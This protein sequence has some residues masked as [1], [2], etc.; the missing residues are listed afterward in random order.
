[1]PIDLFSE[2]N[3]DSAIQFLTLFCDG[4]SRGKPPGDAA[5][6]CV[7]FGQR[8]TAKKGQ[9][10]EEITTEPIWQQG[11]RLGRATN[12]WAEWQALILGLEYILTN[13]S[14]RFPV[15]VFLDSNLVVEQINQNWQVKHPELKL[16]YQKANLMVPKFQQI[17]FQHIFREYNTLADKM[18]N[19]ALDKKE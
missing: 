7:L 4:A 17:H 19:L 13:F 6:G 5:A 2:L 10:L 16:L 18:A 15:Q 11:F 9:L 8:F 14:S 1:M 12:N 3:H